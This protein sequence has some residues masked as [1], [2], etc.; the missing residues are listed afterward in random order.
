M[1]ANSAHCAMSSAGGDTCRQIARLEFCELF[2]R[3]DASGHLHHDE[4]CQDGADRD[5]GARESLLEKCVRKQHQEYELGEARFHGGESYSH[6]QAKVAHNQGNRNQRAN[7]KSQVNGN[8]I[9]Q[10]CQ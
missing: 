1:S 6:H 7:T 9:Y 3:A 5:R 8:V 4:K 10:V 2:V